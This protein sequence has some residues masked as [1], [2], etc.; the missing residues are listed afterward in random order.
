MIFISSQTE[1]VFADYNPDSVLLSFYIDVNDDPKINYGVPLGTFSGTTSEPNTDKI[2]I[3][4]RDP[5]G[6]RVMN[7]LRV[8]DSNGDFNFK[9]DVVESTVLPKE[10]T[11]TATAHIYNEAGETFDESEQ[12]GTFVVT[13]ENI[14]KV[15]E[16]EPEVESEVEPEQEIPPA[17][18][19]GTDVIMELGTSVPGCEETNSCFSPASL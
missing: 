14:F 18:P 8:S 12:A 19:I 7:I 5:D 9:F 4:V 6:E 10:G 2:Y 17:A 16:P 3:T 15:D 1:L 11:Y 13:F